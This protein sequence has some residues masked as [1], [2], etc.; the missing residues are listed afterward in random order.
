MTEE[1][2]GPP[3]IDLADILSEA[4][5]DAGPGSVREVDE[6][7]VVGMA[8]A[9]VPPRG[10]DAKAAAES[11]E[12]EEL[13]ERHLRLHA[14]FENF[15]KRVDREKAELTRI[16]G[17]DLLRQFLPV[18]DSLERAI[19]EAGEAGEADEGGESGIREG[20]LLI[21]RQAMEFLHRAGLEPIEAAG[22]PFDPEFH[23]AVERQTT[24]DYPHHTVIDELQKGYK[25]QGKL[26]RAA[27]VRV[28]YR[29]GDD[30]PDDSRED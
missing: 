14:D 6:L 23:E 22:K 18:L 20:L 11:T 17:A 25:F 3:K 13:K 9:A 15:R 27:M 19:R 7:Q 26:L 10:Q 4:E 29:P 16:A 5:M 12:L 30:S 2:K 21:H 28:A 24:S 8:P 1:P